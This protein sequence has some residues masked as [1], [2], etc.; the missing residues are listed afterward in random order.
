M[1]I[2]PMTREQLI[3]EYSKI[4]LSTNFGADFIRQKI[5]RR[6]ADEFG[7]QLAQKWLSQYALSSV[8]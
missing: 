4:A 6:D 2:N 5:H 1:K 8:Q 3:E 7:Q